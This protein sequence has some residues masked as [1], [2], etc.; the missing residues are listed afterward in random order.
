MNSVRT[1]IVC[2]LFSTVCHASDLAD[3]YYKAAEKAEKAGDSFNA[4]LLYARAASLAPSNVA[5]AAKKTSL[6][7][8]TTLTSYSE[9]AADPAASEKTAPVTDPHESLDSRQVLAP[10][11]L[12]ASDAI[13]SFNLKGDAQKIFEQVASAYGIDVAFDNDYQNPPPFTFRLNDA[14]FEDAMRALEMV[15]NSFIVA[16]NP[17]LALVVRDNPAKRAEKMPVVAATIPIPERFSVQDAQDLLTAVKDSLEIRRA[18]LDPTRHQVVLRDQAGKVAAAERLFGML[19]HIR[20]QVHVDIEFIEVD[21]NSSLAYG[22]SLP[23]QISIVNFVGPVAFPA[24]YAAITHITGAN[25]PYAIGVGNAN[26]IATL[27]RAS[28]NTL[29]DA[30]MVALDGQAATLHVGSKYPIATNQYVGNTSGGT[31]Y[32]PPPTIN[33]EDL[34]VILKITP[35]LQQGDEVALDVE[36]EFKTLGATSPVQGIPIINNRSFKGK[37]RLQEGEWAVVSGLISLTD[38]ETRTGWPGLADIPILGRIFSSNTVEH[39]STKVLVLIKPHV[40]AL[41]G[42]EYLARALWVGTDT[43]PISVF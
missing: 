38:V 42:W 16:L 32:A 18:I 14:T 36:A 12:A 3:S 23:N 39:D 22:I 31:V 20:P 40:T 43:R 27:T 30:Q 19:S 11:Q 24:A 6:R 15:S 28:A 26:I 13:K 29:I 1:L 7:L 9:L 33:F 21:K 17:K 2:L 10:P 41:P 25:S 37:V 35:A 5:Y 4:Y 8:T 34:G